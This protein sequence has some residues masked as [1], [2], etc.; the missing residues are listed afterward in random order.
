MTV[1]G[2][3][4]TNSRGHALTQLLWNLHLRESS[5]QLFSYPHMRTKGLKPPSESTVTEKR[6][7]GTPRSSTR[8]NGDLPYRCLLLRNIA[9]HSVSFLP[10]ISMPQKQSPFRIVSSVSFL[11]DMD[12]HQPA[13]R[14][15]PFPETSSF[16]PLTSVLPTHATARP[17]PRRINTSAKTPGG[18]VPP[19]SK[20]DAFRLQCFQ[21]FTH[22][23]SSKSCVPRR[24][25]IPG[26]GGDI[27]H[28][29]A[30]VWRLQWSQPMPLPARR[31]AGGKQA[32]CPGLPAV[33]GDIPQLEPDQWRLR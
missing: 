17:I 20:R 12:H 25:P 9:S 15:G 28:L 2:T 29:E 3:C 4:Q 26:G 19:Q 5:L 14:Q 13:R 24:L 21:R 31:Q 33:A 22:S 30:N 8:R 16:R 27:P 23:I 18:A 7:W 1:Y 32:P 6:G 11:P 10:A